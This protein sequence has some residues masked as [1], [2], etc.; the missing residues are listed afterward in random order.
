MSKVDT[1]YVCFHPMIRCFRKEPWFMKNIHKDYLQRARHD[2][3]FSR[4]K[5]EFYLYVNSNLC[6]YVIYYK[7]FIL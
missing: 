2:F 7:H 4:V 5:H 1:V 3:S 6:S